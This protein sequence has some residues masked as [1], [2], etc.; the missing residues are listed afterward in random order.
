MAGQFPASLPHVGLLFGSYTLTAESGTYSVSGQDAALRFGIP[1][2]PASLPHI[3][4]VLP[5]GAAQ[6]TL[7]AEYGSYSVTGHDAS[8]S[9]N[10]VVAANFG[11]Y[12]VSGQAG[13]LQA[14]GAHSENPA[15]LPHLGLLLG[16]DTTAY[17]LVADPGF[18]NLIGSDALADFEVTA[19][20]GS[21][22]VTGQ[23]A[24]L[25]K[26]TILTA[27]SGTYSLSGQD[28]AFSIGGTNRVMPADTSTYTITGYDAVLTAAYKLT[29][30]HGFYAL[31]GQAANLVYSP[32]ASYTLIA[33]GGS[34][35]HTGF[36]AVLDARKLYAEYGVYE[37]SGFPVR[38]LPRSN[39]AGRSSPWKRPRKKYTVEIDGEVFTVESREEA[40]TLLA[41]AKEAAE[42]FAKTAIERASK[43]EKRPT[44]RVLSDARKALK[45]PGISASDDLASDAEATKQEIDGIYKSALMTVEIAARMR[46]EEEDEE[47][48]LLMLL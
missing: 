21:Y 37:I 1:W 26:A 15:P 8:S 22:T 5:A 12:V 44:R 48:A 36:D 27:E 2:G 46:R 29:C 16:P 32:P 24:D 23:D 45:T 41:K 47:T 35:S 40:A 38:G 4:S 33:E 3:G 13:I 30:E 17:T 6:Y 14:S 42:E 19:E 10:Y 11:E 25:R 28:V 18:Y 39:A 31:L 20:Q 34:Y 9:R 7:T 43:A